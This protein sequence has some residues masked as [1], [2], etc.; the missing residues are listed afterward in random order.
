MKYS[1]KQIL[2]KAFLV[3]WGL[4]FN[5]IAPII[6]YIISYPELKSK[7]KSF[8]PLKPENINES[9][10]EWVSLLSQL[11]N[12]IET[13]FFKPYWV[14]IQSDSYDYFIDL[15]SDSYSIFE[16]HFFFFEPLC[17]YRKYIFNDISEFLV[18]VDDPSIDLDNQI[19]K[20]YDESMSIVAR[21]FRENEKLGLDDEV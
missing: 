18:S 17:W 4:Q 7:F 12:P 3:E 8:K 11:E 16:I 21:L 20:N 14:P 19:S 9:Q 5:K 1:E 2:F 15:S 6:K 10:L 13:D